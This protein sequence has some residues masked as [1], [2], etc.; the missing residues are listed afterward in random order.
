M[1]WTRLSDDF[2]DRADIMGLS[3]EA[4]R[5]HIVGLVWANRM[6]L[7]GLIPKRSAAVLAAL[8]GL[9]DVQHVVAELLVAGLWIDAETSYQIEWKDQESAAIVKERKTANA[10][11]NRT[12]RERSRLHSAGDHSKCTRC[13]AVRD[14]SRDQSHDKSVTATRTRP[15]PDPTP[16]EEEGEGKESAGSDTAAPSATAAG[17]SPSDPLERMRAIRAVG[18]KTA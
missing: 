14:Q 7:D 18:R 15:E 5:L 17:A 8:A 13:S 2:A 9:D 10:E 4:F 12:W 6:L 1:T 3:A 11:K 16:R